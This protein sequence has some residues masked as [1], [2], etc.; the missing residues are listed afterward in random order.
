[1]RIVTRRALDPRIVAPA[2]AV[3]EAVGRKT[4][5]RESAT[6]RELH[7]D[8]SRVARSAVVHLIDRAHPA[9]IH[10]QC[11]ALLQSGTH[12]GHVIA[13]WPVTCFACNS[14]DNVL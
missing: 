11:S 3:L 8:R 10:D 5:R 12:R 14:S 9:G 6:A 1:M 13:T 2:G 7:V 4:H